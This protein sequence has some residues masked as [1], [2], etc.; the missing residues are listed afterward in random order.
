MITVGEKIKH[1]RLKKDLSQEVLAE[2]L[3][4][5]LQAYNK[6][7]TNKTRVDIERLQQIAEKLD[8]NLVELLSYGDKDIYYITNTNTEQK[9]GNGFVIHNGLPINYINVNEKMK[10]LEQEN[11][12][13]KEKISLLETTITDLRNTVAVLQREK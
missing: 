4:I 3:G 11:S 5:S 8:T 7:E 2:L 12:F 6:I 9:G 1:F 10:L 13:L